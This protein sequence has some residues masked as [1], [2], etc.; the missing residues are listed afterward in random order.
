MASAD[1]PWIDV[2]ID[3]DVHD[4]LTRAAKVDGCSITDFVLKAATVEAHRILE[5]TDTIKLDAE[6]SSFVASLLIDA[7]P[8]PAMKE[9]KQRYD[10]LVTKS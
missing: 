7:K 3:P 6:S 10:Q 4:V 9:A 8:I 2:H 1:Q 5:Q